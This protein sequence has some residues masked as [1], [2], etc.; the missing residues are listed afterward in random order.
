MKYIAIFFFLVYSIFSY[1]QITKEQFF[2]AGIEVYNKG[3]YISAIEKFNEVIRADSLF[4]EA[5]YY[6]GL[7]YEK[8]TLA[9]YHPEVIK[10]YKTAIALDSGKYFWEAYYYLARRRIVKDSL[11]SPYFK[12]AARLN[13]KNIELHFKYAWAFMHKDSS[14]AYENFKL[15]IDLDSNNIIASNNELARNETLI[16]S[17]I[18]S[19]L[20]IHLNDYPSALNYYNKALKSEPKNV[21][22]LIGRAIVFCNLKEYRK[23]KRD[24]KK[25]SKIGSYDCHLDYNC[26]LYYT[27]RNNN[28]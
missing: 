2:E 17:Y 4:A 6:K 14:I 20:T 3:Y 11:I 27:K 12:K 10:N 18:G 15:V 16:L 21:N 5:Y 25:A 23:K 28:P 26:K 13:P 22:I 7:S 24:L 8:G 19:Y 1:G 9:D